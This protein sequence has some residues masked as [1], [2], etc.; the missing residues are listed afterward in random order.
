VPRYYI[1][2]SPEQRSPDRRAS[3]LRRRELAASGILPPNIASSFTGGQQAVLRVLADE[4]LSHGVCDRS[5]NELAARAGTSLTIVKQ[6]IK[7]A[8]RDGLIQVTRRP[9][10]GRKHLCNLVRIIRAD[11]LAWLDKG[12]RKGYAIKT[13]NRAKPDFALP[14]GALKSPP[15]AQVLKNN[16]SDRVDKS[17]EE[18][19]RTGAGRA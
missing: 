8:E 1:E 7:Y 14:R 9:R 12:H 2:R 3:L 16:R 19:N 5:R 4:C 13:C 6:A 10:S 11:W 15:R 17:G 18:E